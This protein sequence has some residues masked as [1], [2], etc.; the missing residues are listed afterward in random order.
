MCSINGCIDFHNP[1]GV[2]KAAVIAAGKTL[3]RRGPDG[4]G[5]HD[6]GG[7]CFYHN[8]LA[9]MD[10]AGGKQ[11]M[12]A[13]FRR[14]RYT[15]VYNG[16]IY[17][18]DAL[19]RELKMQGAVFFT[20]CDTETVLWA[21]MIWGE[22]APS[23][24]NGIFAF[25]VHNETDG[26]VFFA[27]DRLGVKPLYY[28]QMGTKFYFASEPKALLAHPE[29]P[30][31]VDEVG[32][33]QLLL[34][35]PVTLPGQSVFRHVKALPAGYCATLSREDF[36]Q[37]PY[38]QLQ[39]SVCHDD[40]A[41]A[42]ERVRELLVD[43]VTRQLDSDVPLGVLLSGG[44]DSSSIT[45]VAARVL[46]ARGKTLDT[47]SF[48]H[49]GNRESF[50]PTLFQPE[51]DEAY[52]AALAAEL[53]TAHRVLTAPTATIA[54][55]LYA[56][57]LA[58]DLPGQADLDSSL[59]YYCAEIKKQH[60]VVLSGECSDEIFGGYPWFYR[61]EML[62]R[63]FFPW[64]H[65]PMARIGLFDAGAVRA[66]QGFD[67]MRDVYRQSLAD[68]PVVEGESESMR[69]SR[70]A[71]WLSTQYFMANLLERK[72]RMS[73]YAA[74]E[75]RVP[76]A[77]HRILEYVF[78]LPWEVKFENGVEKSLLRRAM[79]GYLPDRVLWR[80]KSPYPKT[81][82]PLYEKLV[83]EML[84]AR[85]GQDGFLKSTLDQRRLA[86]LLDGENSTWFGQLMARPQLVA[87]L[88]QLDFWFEQYRVKL[89]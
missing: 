65:D 3:S 72:D 60:T 41:T 47:Y 38:W 18:S 43:A 87:W 73:M 1:K 24:L 54:A 42:A 83:R 37:K 88:C 66:A 44:L 48:E 79:T 30:S 85:L 75:V 35:A 33:W 29:I 12:S 69:L 80:K 19:R 59:I 28:A 52:A 9:V 14:K 50:S 22:A 55:E 5:V 84:A 2:D 82:N 77:D 21:Y 23:H 10:P 76:F 57:T 67:F 32:L 56:A 8:R 45:A 78:N 74:V 11:P 15:I 27:R 70:R 7:V 63:D 20:E 17:N 62:Q 61:E 86:A 71:T 36:T 64:L 46:A 34:L 51:G 68:C 16:E 53:G 49:E 31:E 39:A 26:T 40:A 81:H 25:A 6:F 58:R 13:M 89:V 4:N